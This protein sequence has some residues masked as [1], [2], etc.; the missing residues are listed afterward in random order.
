[1]YGTTATSWPA[2]CV[3]FA[4]IRETALVVV[5]GFGGGL[6]VAGLKRIASMTSLDELLNYGGLAIRGGSIVASEFAGLEDF[7]GPYAVLVLEA[8]AAYAPDRAHLAVGSI[9]GPGE[10]GGVMVFVAIAGRLYETAADGPAE[11]AEAAARQHPPEQLDLT[12]AARRANDALR[13]VVAQLVPSTPV[14]DQ[15]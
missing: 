3:P 1:M 2:P 10:L 15:L 11:R 8:L 7:A 12:E 5:D 14:L 13:T 6:D 4:D 9:Q